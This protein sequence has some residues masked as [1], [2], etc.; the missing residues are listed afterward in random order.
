MMGFSLAATSISVSSLKTVAGVSV[1]TFCSTYAKDLATKSVAISLIVKIKDDLS[2]KES[3]MRQYAT[4]IS[5]G[6]INCK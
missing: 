2:L 4:F 6:K 5:L 1:N 3:L